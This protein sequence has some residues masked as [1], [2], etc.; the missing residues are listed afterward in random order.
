MRR[1]TADGTVQILLRRMLRPDG[2]PG[3]GSGWLCDHAPLGGGIAL[4]F[5]DFL[6]RSAFRERFE[7]K[8]RMSAYLN[9]IPTAVIVR[10][11]PAF[12]GLS[13]L[14]RESLNRRLR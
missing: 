10:P 13:Y 9:R 4:R 2:T 12:L 5:T 14:A 7:A 11:N 8:G 1:L 3:I 6:R